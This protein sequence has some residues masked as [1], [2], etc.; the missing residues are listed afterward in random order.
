MTAAFLKLFNLSITAGWIV[1]VVLL[2]RLCLKKAPRWIT[3]VLWGIVALRLILPFH[4]ESP[5]SLVP[6]PQFVVQ[7]EIDETTE[8]F[9]DSGV[10]SIDTTLND[11]LMTPV[12]DVENSIDQLPATDSPVVPDDGTEGSSQTKPAPPNTE[13]E[14][15][16][17]PSTPKSRA[18]AVLGVAAPVWLVGVALMLLYELASV[19]LVRRRVLDAVLVRD[20]IWTS[21]RV[22]TTFIFGLFC[23]RI[24]VPYGL[25]EASLEL[26]LAH[27]RSHLQRFDHWIKPFAFTLLAVYW[28]NPLLW[29]AY[30]L[31]CRDI[32]TA[33]DE[34]VIKDLSD[35]HRRLYAAA[36][37]KCGSEHKT[38]VGCPLAFG[39]LSIKQR[40]FSVLSYRKPL[41]F[42]IVTSVMVCLLAAVCLLT[43]P[44]EAIA[45]EWG[46][47][48]STDVTTHTT[49]GTTPTSTLSSVLSTTL[50]NK[51]TVSATT[52]G[53]TTNQVVATKPS[54]N[55]GHM[56]EYGVWKIVM[57]P[58]CVTDGKRERVCA[59]GSVEAETISAVGHT[60]IKNICVTCG[61][62]DG[63]AFIPDCSPED[64]NIVGNEIGS[65][66][67][68]GQGEWLYFAAD[69][70]R[71]MKSRTDGNGMQTIWTGS[72]GTIKNV[73]VVGNWVYFFVEASTATKSYVGKVRTDGDGFAYVLQA[74][75]IGE[76]LVIKDTLF[77]T[78]IKNPYSDYAKDAAPLY[79]MP[80]GGGMTKLM[81]DGHVSHLSS[82]GNYLYFKHAPESGSKSVYR[83]NLTTYARSTLITTF[84][85]THYVIKAGRIYYAP[86]DESTG[87]YILKSAAVT[88]GTVTNHG[89][90]ADSPEWL[91]VIDNC[92]YYYGQPYSEELWNESV[93]IVEFNYVTSRYRV[94]YEAY[95]VSYCFGVGGHLVFMDYV[96]STLSPIRIYDPQTAQ[97]TEL[98]VR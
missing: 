13:Q 98:D 3:C 91:V 56:H 60:Y 12:E 85:A 31:L 57:A 67:V 39:E 26:I 68:A 51:T 64:A 55:T 79:M 20:N 65:Y 95:D 47:N 22:Q 78:I 82:D 42:V 97:W 4:I 70:C 44:Q 10:S 43:V 86:I 52:I 2:L 32:E 87:D 9:V 80:L 24:Y 88:G 37:L 35:D 96:G 6:T 21:D 28:Y 8:I 46:E 59:C 45:T 50:S 30:L 14:T 18:Q 23:P 15:V 66:N 19:I 93:G 33:C 94:I 25:N 34:R 92:L 16:D 5:F 63:T 53:V 77:F 11:W 83:L 58:E 41:L 61:N 48:T 49:L 73:N 81:H 90:I 84:K 27:E 38:L 71:I 17:S 40:I 7:S 69:S 76:M 1:L 89:K 54:S 62:T 74:V 36:L 72:G 29:V 75:N